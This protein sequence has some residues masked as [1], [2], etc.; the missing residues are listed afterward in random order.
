M[1]EVGCGECPR[2]AEVM[3]REVSRV[4]ILLLRHFRVYRTS[5]G[6]HLYCSINLFIA[7]NIKDLVPCP[8]RAAQ[9]NLRTRICHALRWPSASSHLSYLAYNVHTSGRKD[10]DRA[11]TKSTFSFNQIQRQHR[12]HTITLPY[13]LHLILTV[14]LNTYNQ[15]Y[16]ELPR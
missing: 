10:L 1:L 8:R 9:P 16:Y 15:S 5:V 11:Q 2:G 4:I 13:I 14:F 3:N 6:C 7:S 12:N